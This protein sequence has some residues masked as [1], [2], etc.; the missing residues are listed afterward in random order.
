MR[1]ADALDLGSGLAYVAA[2]ARDRAP[3]DPARAPRERGGR[4]A[5]GRERADDDARPEAA[6]RH[7][8]LEAERARGER[9]QERGDDRARARLAH[10]AARE[11]E[12]L[13]RRPARLGLSRVGVWCGERRASTARGEPLREPGGDASRERALRLGVAAGW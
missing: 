2:L 12:L 5:A 8:A 7:A 13:R 6:R 1:G 4:D 10:R 3:E 9:R 11:R